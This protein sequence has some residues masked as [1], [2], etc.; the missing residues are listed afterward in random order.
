[1]V[2]TNDAMNMKMNTDAIPFY[3]AN[4]PYGFLSNFYVAPVEIGGF[5]WPTT[6]HYY[7][8]QKFADP[9]RQAAIRA[10]PTPGVAKQLAWADDT[11]LHSDWQAVRDA[12]MLVALRAKFTQHPAL[13]TQLL[14]TGDTLLVEHTHLDSYWADGG[15]GSGVNRLGLLLMQVRDELRESE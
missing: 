9:A 14:A 2:A 6:E 10:A 1:M 3:A 8:A 4:A 13:R 7:Q 15:D 11:G 5:T 12:V